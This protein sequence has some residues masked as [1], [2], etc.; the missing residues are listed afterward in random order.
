MHN[1]YFFLRQLSQEL[2]RKLEGA[3]LADCF[4]QNKDELVMGFLL[5]SGEEMYIVAVLTS[6]FSSLYIPSVYHRARKNSITLFEELI[7][8]KVME[9]T[10]IPFERFFI[11]NFGEQYSLGFKMYGNRANIV[12]WDREEVVKI[13]K[14]NLRQDR[15]L[16][17]DRLPKELDLSFDSLQSHHFEIKKSVPVLGD[18]PLLYLESNN[19]SKEEVNNKKKLWDEMIEKLMHP[20]YYITQVKGKYILSLLP[21]GDI[22]SEHVNPIEGLNAFYQS[23]YRFNFVEGEKELILNSVARKESEGLSYVRKCE[24]KIEELENEKSPSMLADIIMAN[25]HA[26]PAGVEKV[27]LFDFYTNNDIEIKLKKDLSPQKYAELLY[28][29]S[30]G[31][32]REIEMLYSQISRKKD[33]LQ[34]LKEDREKISLIENYKDLE[35]YKKKFQADKKEEIGEEDKFKTYELMGFKILVGKN[36]DNNEEL[37]Q[38]YAKKNDLW[39]HA[40]DVAGSHVVIKYQPGKNFPKPVIEAAA[41]LAAFYSKR[42]NE[43]LCP[44]IYTEKKFVRKIKGTPA[45]QMKVEKENVIMVVPGELTIDS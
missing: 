15:N 26:I 10:Q 34:K 9:I 41:S 39:L 2:S 44:V 16:R 14:S 8:K 33:E 29:K 31:R 3:E 38:R 32:P 36:A 6:S 37:T 20:K 23:H 27:K 12:L 25:L 42:K 24:A 43:S 17:K 4:S 1:N 35:P 5:P 19:F 11:I 28:R 30:K 18:V 13:F 40:R 7:G 21:I 22:L 45:G